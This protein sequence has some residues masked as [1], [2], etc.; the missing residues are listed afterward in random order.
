MYKKPLVDTKIPPQNLRT[1]LHAVN[2]K[3]KV[4]F[5]TI[6]K[7]VFTKATT[8]VNFERGLAL[9]DTYNMYEK[10]PEKVMVT[11]GFE[12][13]DVSEISEQDYTITLVV[14]TMLSWN[15]SRLII[16]D[17]IFHRLS[18]ENRWFKLAPEE[19]DFLWKP[20]ITIGMIDTWKNLRAII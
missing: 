7:C 1:Q 8:E 17:K 20:S 14:N 19:S 18:V 5:L 13:T 12:V 6:L 4:A 16:N 2:M 10:P 3:V 11:I 15:D 9:P